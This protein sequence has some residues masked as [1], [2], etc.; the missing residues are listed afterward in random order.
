RNSFFHFTTKKP[1]IDFILTLKQLLSCQIETNRSNKQKKRQYLTQTYI[2]LCKKQTIFVEQFD[3]K[4]G[5]KQ[6]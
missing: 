6:T 4:I 1:S 3:N 5:I 2:S